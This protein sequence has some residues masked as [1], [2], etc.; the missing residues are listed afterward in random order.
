M[1]HILKTQDLERQQEPPPMSVPW[2]NYMAE[3]RWPLV[4]LVGMLALSYVYG[5]FML[6]IGILLLHLSGSFVPNL[7]KRGRLFLL[8][9]TWAAS[10]A[11][12]TALGNVQMADQIKLAQA[13]QTHETC[14]AC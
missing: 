3:D 8:F 4:C 6:A 10:A 13:C 12:G 11:I 7:S 2:R 1:E 9:G 5:M 14:T